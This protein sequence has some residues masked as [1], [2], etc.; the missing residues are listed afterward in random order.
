MR[1]PLLF[2]KQGQANM[3]EGQQLVLYCLA[4]Y[5]T[6]GFL[7]GM[8]R[9]VRLCRP[10]EMNYGKIREAVDEALLTGVFW[11]F[12]AVLYCIIEE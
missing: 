2:K 8:V 10:F 12:L 11:L 7:V 6:I 3:E 9:F 1:T 5:A 4:F